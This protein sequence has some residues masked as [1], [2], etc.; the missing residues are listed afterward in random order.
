MFNPRHMQAFSNQSAWTLALT[1][2]LCG[3]PWTLCVANASCFYTLVES[4]A[5]TPKQP[6]F[7]HELWCTEGKRKTLKQMKGTVLV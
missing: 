2:R 7:E 1:T 4:A 3:Q 6:W 5:L